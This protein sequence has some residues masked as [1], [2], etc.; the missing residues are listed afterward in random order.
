M[1]E[2]QWP[3]TTSG[4]GEHFE[5]SPGIRY[6]YGVI[7]RALGAESLA[8]LETRG[9]AEK[10]EGLMKGK[11]GKRCIQDTNFNQVL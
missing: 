2:T 11:A 9:I 7:R 4:N 3:R 1:P 6:V 8:L 10:K 5:I